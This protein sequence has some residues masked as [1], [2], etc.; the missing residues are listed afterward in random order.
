LRTSIQLGNGGNATDWF[1]LAMA[2]W[3]S[4][5]KDTAR[6]WYDKAVARTKQNNPTDP[7]LRQFWSEAAD[8]FGAPGPDPADLVPSPASSS[9]GRAV[10]PTP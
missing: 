3:R 5:Q 9:K 6:T 2:H 8:L 7:D 1:F 4:G 10:A